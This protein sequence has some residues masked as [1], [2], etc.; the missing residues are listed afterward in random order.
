M[1]AAL[2]LLPENDVH[3]GL[4]NLKEIADQMPLRTSPLNE[5]VEWVYV[6]TEG[7]PA[8]FSH[9]KNCPWEPAMVTFVIFFE[10]VTFSPIPRQ[11]RVWRA[12]VLPE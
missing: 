5:Y 7:S 8:R 4:E 12:Y 6:G 9:H 3:V 10:Q 1:I 2:A 11:L